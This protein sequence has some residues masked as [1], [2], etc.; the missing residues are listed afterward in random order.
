MSTTPVEWRPVPG[1]EG[2]YSVSDRG[3]VLAHERSRQCGHPG[4]AP[5]RRPAVLLKGNPV[6][7]PRAHLAVALTKDGVR[8]HFKIHQLVMLAFVGPCPEGLE[9]L[10][11]DDN[12]ENNQLGNLRYGTRAENQLDAVRNG[13]NFWARRTHCVNGHELTEENTYR[14]PSRPGKRMCRACNTDRLRAR[15]ARKSTA[16][17]RV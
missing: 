3:E 7:N 5:Q 17:E 1:Y 9:V 13:R 16:M 6:G 10:H 14:P 4:S 2:L 8:R 15:R 12:P 11:W